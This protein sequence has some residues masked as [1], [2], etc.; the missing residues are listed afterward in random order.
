MNSED[1]S[2]QHASEERSFSSLIA[3]LRSGSQE[4]AEALHR[5]LSPIVVRTIRRKMNRS[6]RGGYDSQDF[7]QAVWASFFGHLSQIDRFENR[8]ELVRFLTTVASNKVIDAGRRALVR[9]DQSNGAAVAP[10]QVLV[11]HRRHVSE[12][13]PSQYA[14]AQERWDML[15]EDQLPETQAVLRLLK[16]GFKQCEI[17]SQLGISDRRIRRVI[18][19]LSQKFSSHDGEA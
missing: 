1:N 13:T 18:T 6:I 11:D 17:A 2:S 15:N 7:T 9:K 16:Q 19:S 14:V 4:A 3:L 5:S 10:S 8:E 12:P